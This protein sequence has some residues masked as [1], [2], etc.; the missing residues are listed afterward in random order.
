MV[1]SP[2]QLREPTEANY[3]S[4]IFDA[5]RFRNRMFLVAARVRSIK[6]ES[7]SSQQAVRTARNGD[8]C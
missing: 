6:P 8:G 5:R 2:E 3:R 4:S 1:L 7:L